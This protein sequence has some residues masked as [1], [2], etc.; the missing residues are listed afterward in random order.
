MKFLSFFDEQVYSS[1]SLK[2]RKGAH[3]TFEPGP[4]IRSDSVASGNV[5]DMKSPRVSETSAFRSHIRADSAPSGALKKSKP[6]RVM[7][8]SSAFRPVPIGSGPRSPQTSRRS[9]APSMPPAL[10]PPSCMAHVNGWRQHRPTEP[11]PF[12]PA[13]SFARTQPDGDT[14]D[15]RS[16]ASSPPGGSA[17]ISRSDSYKLANEE[18]V[19]HPFCRNPEF[20]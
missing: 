18:K 7:E 3:T 16:S 4:H 10:S 11:P 20:L 12:R 8:P 5:P 9:S 15:G 17:G 1:D 13:P 19:S 14:G 6:T 2:R